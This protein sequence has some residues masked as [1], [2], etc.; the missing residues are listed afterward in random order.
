MAITSKV[1]QLELFANEKKALELEIKKEKEISMEMQ[2]RL[3]FHEIY[4]MKRRLSK[5]EEIINSL[6]DIFLSDEKIST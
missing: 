3:H 1:T 2:V 4:E 5:Q 6:V